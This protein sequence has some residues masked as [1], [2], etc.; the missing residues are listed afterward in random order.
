MGS[1]TSRPNNATTLPFMT[2]QL[3]TADSGKLKDHHFRSEPLNPILEG[4]LK[5]IPHYREI[6]TEQRI[7]DAANKVIADRLERGHVYTLPQRCR[8]FDDEKA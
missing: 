6:W 5:T 1:F 7:Q 8:V 2:L 4:L 3:F